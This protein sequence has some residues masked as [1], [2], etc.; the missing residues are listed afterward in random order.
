MAEIVVIGGGVVGAAAAYRLARDGVRATLIDRADSGQAT[1][2]GAG[3]ICP[4]TSLRPLPAF[5]PFAAAA[6]GHYPALLDALAADGAP[7]T[8]YETVGELLVA[9]DDAAFEDLPELLALFQ[10]RQAAGMPNLGQVSAIDG[11][12]A[13]ERFPALG[14]AFGALWV[15][16]AARVDG[17]LLRDA[18]RHAALGRGAVMLQGEATLVRKGERISAVR[19]DDRTVAC[20]AVIIAGGAWSNAF[21]S[22]LNVTIPVEPQRGQILHLTL[23]GVETGRWPIVTGMRDHYLLTFPPDRVVAGATRETGS[24][25][26]ARMTAGGVHEALNEALRVAPGLASAT[27]REVR[28]GLRPLSPDGLPLLGPVSGLAN[29]YLATGH[30]PSGLQLGP[31]SGEVVARLAQN[32]TIDPGLDLMPFA[33][34]R[35]TEPRPT[36]SLEGATR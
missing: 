4:G 6:V 34:G 18:L 26:D 23:P 15:P 19:V 35:F 2:A 33:V 11:A 27:L 31:Y 17:R 16:G 36:A 8:G 25:Y 21:G 24:G 7:P 10:A 28:I 30:G 13:R 12:E 1:A 14:D 32:Q 22:V 29:A 5:F 3:I 9:T 20:D